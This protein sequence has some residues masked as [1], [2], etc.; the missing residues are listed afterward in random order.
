M[1]GLTGATGAT[2]DTGILGSVCIINNFNNPT[3]PTGNIG[4][5]GVIGI[6]GQD[7]QIG[8]TGSIGQIG[9]PGILGN[10]GQTGNTGNSGNLGNIGPTGQTG[11]TGTQG[12]IG[13]TG[14]TGLTGFAGSQ[15]SI[16]FTGIIGSVGPTGFTGTNTKGI[17]GMTGFTGTQGHQGST[18]ITGF[19]PKGL[20]GLTGI[21][22]ATGQTGST[23]VIPPVSAGIVT[24]NGTTLSSV[25]NPLPVSDGGIGTSSLTAMGVLS[26]N[27]T[28]AVQSDAPTVYVASSIGIPS[29]LSGTNALIISSNQTGLTLT[30]NQ[31]AIIAGSAGVD[32]GIQVLGS[33]SATL[34]T[35]TAIQ[36]GSNASALIAG[37]G[38]TINTSAGSIIL[39][40]VANSN[41]IG[42]TGPNFAAASTPGAPSSTTGTNSMTL[43]SGNNDVFLNGNNLAIIASQGGNSGGLNLSGLNSSIFACGQDTGSTTTQTSIIA[44]GSVVIGGTG[45]QLLIAGSA[46]NHGST[47]L[48][49]AAILGTESVLFQ[50]SNSVTT[51]NFYSVANHIISDPTAKRGM[52]T[53]TQYSDTTTYVNNLLGIT[54]VTYNLKWEDQGVGNHYG[55]DASQLSSLCPSTVVTTADAMMQCTYNI[56]T[57]IWTGPEGETIS[58]ELI[59]KTSGYLTSN[60]LIIVTYNAV[61]DNWSDNNNN[62]YID[63]AVTPTNGTSYL[64]QSLQFMHLNQA[65]MLEYIVV[66]LQKIQKQINLITAKPSV[67]SIDLTTIS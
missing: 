65:S 13:N 44:S 4:T 7:G 23:G 55:F 49:N 45:S 31:S 30:G 57:S 40:S 17:T 42:G 52:A 9:D 32:G 29:T 25:A 56:D 60:P 64:S 34:A 61:T 54:P 50:A 51:N 48:I 47:A 5:Q 35:G 2:G 41:H 53:D 10:I 8:Q 33:P 37:Q 12:P 28:S 66:G 26:G 20:Q 27:G 22:G 39:A 59:M 58:S 6:T 14:A 36:V 24:S 18:G 15:G 11:F 1:S 62:T 63:T 38:G 43:A 3:G 46:L 21:N 67:G 19:T 16:G